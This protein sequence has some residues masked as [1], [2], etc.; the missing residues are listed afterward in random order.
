MKKIITYTSVIL[1]FISG[2]YSCKKDSE[3][4][5]PDLGYEYFPD[6]VGKYIIYEVDSIGY[7]DFLPSPPDTTRYL[8]KEFVESIFIDNSGRPTMRIERYK[9]MYNPSVPYDSLPWILSDI[10]TANRTAT[11]SE[12]V[13]EN[14]RY[15]KLVFPVAKGKE[16]N[17]NVFNTLGQKEYEM[18]SIDKPATIGGLLFDSVITVTQYLQKT[19]IDTIIEEEKFAK[20]IGL[21]YKKQDSIYTGGTNPVKRIGRR[22]TQKIISYGK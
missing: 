7:D 10:W 16:W 19:F 5:P 13:E 1:F 8:L 6:D 21:I 18:T 2:I 11:T 17:G 14:I 9:K 12:K 15:I 22:F 20:H 4:T 3:T